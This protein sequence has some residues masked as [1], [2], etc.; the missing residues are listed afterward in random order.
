[1]AKS[2]LKWGESANKK[3]KDGSSKKVCKK[4]ERRRKQRAPMI[5]TKRR[6]IATATGAKGKKRCTKFTKRRRLGD[7]EKQR[8]TDL[9][10]A[11]GS[12]RQVGKHVGTFGNLKQRFGPIPAI[13]K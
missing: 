1:M 4:W 11:L 8:F 10:K 3:K 6:C 5:F 7:I 9:A 13:P 12:K 2:C